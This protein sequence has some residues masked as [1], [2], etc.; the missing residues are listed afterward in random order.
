[1]GIELIWMQTLIVLVLISIFYYIGRALYKKRRLTLLEKG[2]LAVTLILVVLTPLKL[3]NREN[4]KVVIKSYDKKVTKEVAI[5]K[6]P[7]VEYSAQ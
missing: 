5:K 2:V 1:M 4:N 3:D 7:R 6:E